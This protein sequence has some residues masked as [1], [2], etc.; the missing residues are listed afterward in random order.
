MEF[1]FSQLNKNLLEKLEIYQ[2]NVST[3]NFRLETSDDKI[4]KQDFEN[5]KLREDLSNF[6]IFVSH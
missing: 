1:N 2:K 6:Q 4:K 5:Q 3:I